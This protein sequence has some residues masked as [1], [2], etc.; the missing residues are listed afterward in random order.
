MKILALLSHTDHLDVSRFFGDIAEYGEGGE[1]GDEGSGNRS[2]VYGGGIEG[3]PTQTIETQIAPYKS[4]TK[5]SRPIIVYDSERN[6]P[7]NCP[8][9]SSE[10][11]GPS[12][13]FESR[14]ESGN[15]R[16]ARRVG[17]FEYEFVLKSDLYT[18]R[19][20]Q[21][22]F[23][24]IENTV[25]GIDYK[26]R[27]VNLLKKDSLYNYGMRPLIYSEEEFKRNA[28]GWKRTGHH[29][30]YSRNITNLQC[31]L[32][33]RG[34]PYYMLEW[35]MEFPY[36]D[37][38]YYLAHCYPYTFTDLKDDL[39]DLITQPSTSPWLKREVLCETRAGNSCFLVTITDFD[40][41]DEEK[42]AV[43]LSARVHPGESQ[44][45]WMMKGIL[46][47]LTSPHVAAQELR[48]KFIFKIVPMLNP[49]GVII[50]NYRCSLVGRDL[51]RNFRHPIKS[52]CPT[53]WYLKSMIEKLGQNH[54]A[55]D[56]FSFTSCK[57]RI[58]KC[59]E[60][61][62]RVVMWR[63]LHIANSFTMEAA[64]SGSVLDRG[65]KPCHFSIGDYEDMG[66]SLC[67][68]IYNFHKAQADERLQAKFTFSLTR[69]ITQQLMKNNDTSNN[70][71]PQLKDILRENQQNKAKNDFHASKRHHSNNQN[72]NRGDEKD[73][74]EG[75]IVDSAVS[76][77]NYSGSRMDAASE[78]LLVMP[79]QRTTPTYGSN[80]KIQELMMDGSDQLDETTNNPLE[81]MNGCLKLLL[82]L[83]ATEALVESDSS[84]D[85][86]SDTDSEIKP[87]VQ[88]PPQ[89]RRESRKKRSRC[90]PPS[91]KTSSLKTAWTKDS[92]K[93][94]TNVS[95][96]AAKK[97][98]KVSKYLPHFVSKYDGRTNGGIPCYSKERSLER[99]AAKG[100]EY[101][102]IEGI[103]FYPRYWTHVDII[104]SKSHNVFS[105]G[106]ST[107][108][109]SFLNPTFQSQIRNCE[110]TGYQV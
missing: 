77:L 48:K 30:L 11:Y 40:T 6:S 89:R 85:S 39:D 13:V 103:S 12:L 9:M 96:I 32:L 53:V 26:F 24:R 16:Q 102:H 69:Q 28:V 60:S 105:K 33:T 44:S 42:Q 72:Q 57:F 47:F 100:S 29:I 73:T 65:Q 106:S 81:T 38:Q 99:I 88:K 79:Q 37:S 75:E 110:N 35:Q 62:G 49:D 2:D 31:P 34:I 76:G 1:G 3:I 59:K 97:E 74:T 22:Y 86:D 7:Y 90:L 46:Y 10:D 107:S 5:W 43:V 23:F 45:S 19:H 68:A 64:F 109:K 58:R 50:G 61:T 8:L 51:N 18:N 55:P 52:S 98:Q 54:Q 101:Q 63:Q 87:E 92:S 78:D 4:H 20:T 27:I 93:K 17:Q 14:F 25:P 56:K 95:S 71:V 67:M 91:V 66:K 84:S 82:S 21:W 94:K 70:K 104:H 80:D 41:S 108:A 15:L 36:A 83:K